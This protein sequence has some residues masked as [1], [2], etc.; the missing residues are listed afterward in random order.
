MD[1]KVL[2][3]IIVINLSIGFYKELILKI[4][5]WAS[6]SSIIIKFIDV[7]GFSIYP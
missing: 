5:I 3:R 2:K 4:S 1:R 6:Y 7:F